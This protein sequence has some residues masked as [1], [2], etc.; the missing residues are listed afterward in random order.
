MREH[1]RPPRNRADQTDDPDEAVDLQTHHDPGDERE[2]SAQHEMK[3]RG[4]DETEG[5][6]DTSTSRRPVSRW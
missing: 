5:D 2:P 3:N 6:G 1:D 4:F